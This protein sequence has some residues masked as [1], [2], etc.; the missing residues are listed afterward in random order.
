M[1]IPAACFFTQEALAYNGFPVIEA[2]YLSLSSVAQKD[3]GVPY[4]IK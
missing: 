1:F 4:C 3:M 2:T